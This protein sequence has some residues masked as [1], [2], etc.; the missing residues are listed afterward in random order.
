MTAGLVLAALLAL[1]LAAFVAWPLW[2]G[3]AVVPPDGLDE[4]RDLQSQRDMALAALRDLEDDHETGKLDEADYT[5][6]KARLQAQGVEAMQRIDALIEARR[7]EAAQ[8]PG[9]R[10]LPRSK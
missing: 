9:P 5:E 8:P 10:P 2:R 1:V 4:A 6:L 3:G 7:R